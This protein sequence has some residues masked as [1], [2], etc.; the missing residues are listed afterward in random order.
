M[1]GNPLSKSYWD[2]V[3]SLALDKLDAL[4]DYVADQLT[5]GGQVVGDVTITDPAERAAYYS[6]LSSQGALE[7]LPVVSHR[8]YQDMTSQFARDAIKTLGLD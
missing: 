1:S 7:H 4:L 6:Q 5:E 2:D 8:L 3:E